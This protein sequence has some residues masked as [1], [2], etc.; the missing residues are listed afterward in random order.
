LLAVYVLVVFIASMPATTWAFKRYM[1]EWNRAQS[2]LSTATVELVDGIQVVKTYGDGSATS[3]RFEKAVDRL[4]A[5][6]YS[7]TA[8]IGRPAAFINIM[9]FPGSMVAVIMGLGLL[10]LT[11]GWAQPVDVISFLLVGVGLPSGYLQMSQLATGLRTAA[12]G[13]THID[14]LLHEPTLPAPTNP[15]IPADA[16]VVF[17]HVG[18]A[19]TDGEP[20]LHDVSLTL[21]P[22]TVTA[23]VGPSGSGKTTVSRLVPR[24][25]DVSSGSVSIGGVDVRQIPTAQL[26]G[27]IAIV[28]Q[29]TVLLAD[30]VCENIRIGRP[31]ATDA[32]VEQAAR[33]AQIHE[34]IC[35]LPNGYDTVIGSADGHLSGGELQ[36]VTIA[37]AILQDAPIVILD[38]ATANADP[39]SE[40]EIQRALTRLGHG[41]TLLVIAHRLSTIVHAD[42][43]IVLDKGHIAEQGRHEEL[44]AAGGLYA[45]LWQSQNAAA[46]RAGAEQ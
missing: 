14:R 37:R 17:D 12:L 5:V 25:W 13:A 21:S 26:L 1:D 11:H 32:E 28:F 3:Q 30:T 2:A 27:R 20:V 41:R 46:E 6:A 45:D 23:L 16:T 36:R 29:D 38:E 39:H 15:Q 4:T 31:G 7:W 35:A 42:R 44:L 33:D 22:G 18:F 9:F 19:Y 34:R 40:V 10:C 8:A 24:F 43:I